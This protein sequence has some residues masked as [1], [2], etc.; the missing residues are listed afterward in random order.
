MEPS[1]GSGG[2]HTSMAQCYTGIETKNHTGWDG[3]G[4]DGIIDLPVMVIQ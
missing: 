4:G 2:A 3:Q 1:I